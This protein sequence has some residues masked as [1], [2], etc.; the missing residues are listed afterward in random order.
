MCYHYNLKS[1]GAALSRRFGKKAAPGIKPV[2]L[3]VGFEHPMM[4]VVTESEIR[5]M[6][7]GLIPS[8]ISNKEDADE[9]QNKTLN[10][11]SE[12]VETKPAFSDSFLNRRCLIPATGFFEWQHR[13]KTKVPFFISL[14]GEEIF[15]FAGIFDCFHPYGEADPVFSFSILTT[16]AN[17][18][19]Q[20]IHNT[21]K[22]MPVI[23]PKSNEEL[24]LKSAGNSAE[25]HELFKP[26]DTSAMQAH[27][28]A[29]PG[30][31]DDLLKHVPYS[32]PS[33]FGEDSDFLDR[34][35]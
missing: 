24:W 1:D 9:I 21:Q 7:W 2:P 5:L 18:L 32:A 12:T 8:W 33:L 26:F 11:R 4:P 28:V 20:T 25:L 30:A 16:E 14:K 35:Q 3:A 29:K 13:G 22:R 10:A 6:R 34:F 15:A 27:T 17:S 31:T 19:M 23:L